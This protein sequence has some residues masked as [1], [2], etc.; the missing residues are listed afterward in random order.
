MRK[1]Y[2]YLLGES[3]ESLNDKQSKLNFLSE[4]DDFLNKKQYTRITL[5]NWNEDPLKEIQGELTSG[6]F[7]SDGSSS[8]RNSCS[9]QASL[10]SGEYN[11]D[12]FKN[13]FAINKKVFLE[14]GVKNYSKFYED[15]P[16]LWFPKGVFYISFAAVNSSVSSGL[17]I[18]LTLKD[19]MCGLNGEI[20]GK[21]PSTVILDSVDTQSASGDYISE[22]V[23]IFNIIQELVHHYGGEPLNNIV[24]E[25]VP[26]R[27]RKIQKWMGEEPLYL[28]RQGNDTGYIY[29][30]AM[31]EKPANMNGI[32]TYPTNADIGYIYSDF[33]FDQDL[34]MN[35]N[36]TIVD[37]LEKIKNYLGNYEYFYDEYGIFHFREIKNY[38][39][40]TQAKIVLDDMKRFDYLVD[41]T[42]QKSSYTF[43]NKKNLIAVSSTPQYQNIR[44]DYV[45][46]GTREGT[47]NNQKINV[48]YHLAIDKKPIAGNAYKDLLV[49][50]EEL[51]GLTRLAFPQVVST[52]SS[53]PNPG[54]FNLI[55]R[56][57]DTNSF[58]FWNNNA[59]KEI[60]PIK[61]Y[62]VG[63][64][65]YITKDW[66]T[67][68]Y[69]QG[70]LA[71]NKGTDQGR[72]FTNL[73]RSDITN[74]DWIEPIYNQNKQLKIDVDFYFEELDA[75]WPQIYDLENQKFYGQEEEQTLHPQ[76]LADG[77]YYLDFIEPSTS[78]LG[79]YSVQNIGRR[80][81]VLVNQDIN[82]LFQPEI[83]NVIWLN[84]DDDKIVE[85]RQEAIK[86]GQPY[87]Q[88]RGDIYSNF[89]TGGYKNSAFDAVKT[90]LW[91]YT[92]YQKVLSLTTVPIFYLTPNTRITVSDST[93]N[94]YGDYVIKSFSFSFGA[95][96]Q[97]NISCNQCIDK[98]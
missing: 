98:M 83:P 78:G 61:Y 32:L 34:T 16:I 60:T 62:P 63:G 59:Y 49:Y 11:S 77:N 26:L 55:Y 18:S 53:L 44:N 87:S 92:T 2:P 31:T 39:N 3:D 88:V 19:K 40:T 14:I 56:T 68:M 96:G 51:S 45:I 23:L 22:K 20:G 84:A 42:V 47:G 52:K 91:T 33:V 67:E 75:F 38:L 28:K 82:C 43:S 74:T 35:A 8:V 36:Q 7:T 90:Q 10:N 89:W 37:A 93:T 70:L 58:F 9:L 80:T 54:N 95:S 48:M 65:G 57:A 30:E 41:N 1:F 86:M 94:T 81:E 17:S 21:F 46:Q 29:F 64:P 6:T 5:L 4:I 15:Y 79:Q 27:I 66:R 24:I 50:K 12:D 72:F 85:N 69:L 97:M 76:T 73:V 13:D 25:D 71:K